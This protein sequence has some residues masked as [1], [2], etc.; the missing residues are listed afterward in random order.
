MALIDQLGNPPKKMSLI[1]F[2]THT[3]NKVT[4]LTKYLLCFLPLQT[5]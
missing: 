3:P 5:I 2:Q 1:I 4:E